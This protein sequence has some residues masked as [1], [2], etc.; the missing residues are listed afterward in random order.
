MGGDPRG[1][2]IGLRESR[3]DHRYLQSYL[4]IK[5]YD[6]PLEYIY[7]NSTINDNSPFSKEVQE[8]LRWAPPLHGVQRKQQGDNLHQPSTIFSNIKSVLFA[9]KAAFGGNWLK[10]NIRHETRCIGLVS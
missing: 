10:I 9:L 4:F 5:H 7:I 8:C 6:W 3:F 1:S 2:V